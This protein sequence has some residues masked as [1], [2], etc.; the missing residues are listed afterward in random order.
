MSERKD[1]IDDAVEAVR[2]AIDRGISIGGG[3]AFNLIRYVMNEATNAD[4]Y[5][6]HKEGFTLVQGAIGQPFTQL[7]LN[8][9]VEPEKRRDGLIEGKGYNVISD[10]LVDLE[11]YTI[12]DPTGVLIDS[13]SNAVAV[14]KSVLSI[15]CSIY[16]G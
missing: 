16:N 5:M 8:A 15:E 4:G 3:Y 7:C 6:K 1:R 13:I 14:A 9:G 11:E 2:A 10:K 12:Y